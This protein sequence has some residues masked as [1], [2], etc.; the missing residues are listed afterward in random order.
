[1]IVIYFNDLRANLLPTS[2]KPEM[3]KFSSI[4][5]DGET[6]RVI[7]EKFVSERTNSHKFPTFS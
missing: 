7:L 2:S 5:Q 6:Y 1:M 3:A 4:A